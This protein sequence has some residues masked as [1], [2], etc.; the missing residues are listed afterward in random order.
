[1]KF[2]V[3][4]KWRDPG[5]HPVGVVRMERT[6]LL[7]VEADSPEEAVRRGEE[8]GVVV[9][10]V[11]L[12]SDRIREKQENDKLFRERLAAEPEENP[13]ERKRRRAGRAG[14]LLGLSILP[15][16]VYAWLNDF[17]PLPS[18]LCLVLVG[19]AL[20]CASARQSAQYDIVSTYSPDTGPG[21][22]SYGVR[23]MGAAAFAFSIVFLLLA[24]IQLLLAFKG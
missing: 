18:A 12:E 5:R 24:G 2:G 22:V 20:A 10:E 16:F 14:F 21:S 4:G 17:Q 7:T 15:A 1:M 9:E 3:Y 8:A 19:V 6:P 11:R 23:Q 13:A